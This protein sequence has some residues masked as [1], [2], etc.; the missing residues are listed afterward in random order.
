MKDTRIAS[1]LTSNFLHPW[2]LN[3]KS[4]LKWLLGNEH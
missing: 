4:F 2:F 1:D 3:L